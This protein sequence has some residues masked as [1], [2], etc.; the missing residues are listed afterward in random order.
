MKHEDDIEAFLLTFEVARDK[1]WV[2]EH[3]AHLLDPFLSGEA[4]HANNKASTNTQSSIS[5]PHIS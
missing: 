3:W 4:Q 5:L 2:E 1:H